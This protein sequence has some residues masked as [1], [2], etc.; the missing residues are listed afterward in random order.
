MNYTRFKNLKP[1]MQLSSALVGAKGYGGEIPWFLYV[2]FN[3]ILFNIIK[4][5]EQPS[6]HF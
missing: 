6:S 3:A 1:Y 4:H 5:R 2:P